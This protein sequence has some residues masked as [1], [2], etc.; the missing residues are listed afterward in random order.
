MKKTPPRRLNWREGEGGVPKRDHLWSIQGVRLGHGSPSGPLPT[1][2]LRS[3][4]GAEDSGR[5]MD[6]KLIRRVRG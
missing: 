4:V 1:S 2:V 3:D 6:F 5:E